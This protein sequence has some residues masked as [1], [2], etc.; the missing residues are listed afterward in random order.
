[1]SEIQDAERR[2]AG[3]LNE[4]R[5]T[6]TRAGLKYVDSDR[7]VMGGGVAVAWS[8]T[9]F[10]ML[11][12]ANF[13][14]EQLNITYGILRNINQDRLAALEYCNLHNQNFSAY[15]AYLHDAE[16]GWDIL[17]QNVLPL[18]ILRESPQFVLGFYLGGSSQIVDDLRA[19]ATEVGLGG[20]PYR[21]NEEDVN[22]LLAKSLM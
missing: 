18:Q 11:S 17:Q 9:F 10:V 19:K 1:M 4:I 21:W 8:E 5:Q 20:E 14:D 7:F 16:N 6:L 22:R 13:L 12:V 2:V 15:P 3:S